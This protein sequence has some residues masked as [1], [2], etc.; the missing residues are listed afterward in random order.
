MIKN[1]QDYQSISILTMVQK[2]PIEN[3]LN[4]SLGCALEAHTR[5]I[6]E[7]FL[8]IWDDFF[9]RDEEGSIILTAPVLVNS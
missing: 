1:D 5:S 8:E 6:H 7:R 4:F 3:R 2:N 9:N